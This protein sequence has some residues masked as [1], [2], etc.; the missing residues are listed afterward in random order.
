[1]STNKYVKYNHE[2]NINIYIN[3]ITDH[4]SLSLTW[5]EHRLTLIQVVGPLNSSRTLQYSSVYCVVL[6]TYRLWVRVWIRSLFV[7]S[8]P[9]QSFIWHMSQ[10]LPEISLNKALIHSQFKLPLRIMQAPISTHSILTSSL[11]NPQVSHVI[12][13]YM[14]MIW[15]LTIS[16][17]RRILQ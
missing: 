13:C 9:R 11:Y 14:S 10:K 4:P 1:M 3:L 2:T 5:I 16:R 12:S 8:F 15:S 17:Q 7:G 6:Q